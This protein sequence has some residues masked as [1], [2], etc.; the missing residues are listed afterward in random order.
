MGQVTTNQEIHTQDGIA[1]LDEGGVNSRVGRG[2]GK[3]LDVHPEIV[4]VQVIGGKEFRSTPASECFHHV[5]VF[6][7]L[8]VP[9]VT[10]AAIAPKLVGIIHDGFFVLI[11][12][13]RAGIAFGID[14]G[15]G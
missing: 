12:G 4:R 11:A 3:R 14:I 6:N 13:F 5:H 9:G 10:V 7:S 8:V 1:R 2:T 15:E